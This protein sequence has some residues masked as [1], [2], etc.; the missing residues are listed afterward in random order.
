VQHYTEDLSRSWLIFPLLLLYLLDLGGVGLLLPDEPRYASIG[1]E[2]AHSHDFITP[3]LDG[4][5]WFEKPPLLFWMVAAGHIVRLPDEWAARL[6]VALLSIAFLIFFFKLIEREFSPRTAIG[7]SIILATSAGWLAYSFV[8]VTDV[9]MA[10]TFAAAMLIAIFDTRPRQGYVSGALLGLSIL[11]KGFV[12]VVLFLPMFFVERGKRL[13]T[14]AGCIA[15]AA[16]WHLL[17]WARNGPAF[18]QDYMWKQQVLR[19]FSPSLQHVQPFWFYVPVILGGLF[20]WTPLAGLL[21]QR[22]TYDDVRVRFLVAWLFYALLFFSVAKN[23]LP[24]YALPLLPPLAISLAVAIDKAGTTARW[25]LLTSVLMLAALPAIT[26]ALPEALL[27]GV[28]KAPFVFG[29]GWPFVVP[30]AIVWWLAWREKPNLAMIA[31]G[32]TIVFGV[33]YLKGKTFPILDDRVSVR[34]F[35]RANHPVNACI[36]NV[37]RDWEYG[38]NYYAGHALPECGDTETGPRITVADQRLT[39]R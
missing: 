5:P 30:A 34:A 4:Q 37:R 15:V 19:F 33:A 31:A 1:R 9:P 36:E 7:A 23:K 38:L 2:M 12:P 28:R 24:G 16:P 10:A 6:P 13:T 14:L 22:K 32:M 35:W 25:W 8:A 27:S 17:C 11:G 29:A 3:R 18:W 26:T 39:I 21:L 20:P